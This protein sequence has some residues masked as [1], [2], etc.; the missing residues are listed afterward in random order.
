MSDKLPALHFYPGDWWKDSGVQS[1]DHFHKG[2]WFE[3]LLIMFDSGS[4]G[5]LLLNGKQYP[6]KALAKRL[7]ITEQEL[8][9]AIEV[10]VVSGVC[11]VDDDGVFYSHRMV[12][13][14]QK[15]Q[16]KINA[17][18]AGG[19]AKAA[20][21][22][23]S[24]DPSKSLAPPEVESE[25]ENE[26]EDLKLNK[27]N[28]KFCKLNDIEAEQLASTTSTEQV[29][30]AIQIVDAWVLT[31]EDQPQEFNI[32]K[33]KAKK[34]SACLSGWALS[35]AL[36]QLEDEKR[37]KPKQKVV[38]GVGAAHLKNLELIARYEAEEALQNAK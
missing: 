20:S 13:D 33:Q 19:K 10:L 6:S 15:R 38:D 9:T 25:I 30:R 18:A 17:G 5:K 16:I 11:R 21:K 23:V 28:G 4:R 29:K 14:E 2:I 27:W 37:A 36:I 35:R 26:V 34:G 31:A 3:L 8:E 7:A 32:R 24:K 22:Q 12:S 1:L